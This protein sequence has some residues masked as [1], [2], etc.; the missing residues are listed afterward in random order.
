M[1][2]RTSGMEPSL[3]GYRN[4]ISGRASSIIEIVPCYVSDI[5]T[6]LNQISRTGMVPDQENIVNR[7]QYEQ[8]V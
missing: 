8:V 3:S 1:C 2:N 5:R 4:R 7:I 6:L